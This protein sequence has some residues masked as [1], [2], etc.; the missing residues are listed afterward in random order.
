M[1]V[2]DLGSL[3]E[4][5]GARFLPAAPGAWRA[6]ISKAEWAR[7]AGAVAGLRAVLG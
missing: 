3:T 4:L 5:L 2:A 1:Y 6:E 7:L